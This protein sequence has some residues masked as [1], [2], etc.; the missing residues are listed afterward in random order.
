MIVFMV[1]KLVM[2]HNNE[3]SWRI[4]ENAFLNICFIIYEFK[5]IIIYFVDK[6]KERK[7]VKSKRL[8]GML[9]VFLLVSGSLFAQ[10]RVYR[11]GDVGPAGGI[12][13][14]DKGFSQDGWR[15]LEVAPAGAE[16]TAEWGGRRL[17]VPGTSA[18][19]GSGKRNTQL[20]VDML[21]SKGEKE[22]AAQLCAG[23]DINGFK[24]WFLPSIDELNHL[25]LNRDRIGGFQNARYWSST[26][27]NRNAAK[28]VVFSVE[29]NG[30]VIILPG[31][32][33]DNNKFD[34]RRVRPVRSF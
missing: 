25:Y 12:I 24:D 4:V 13:Y 1:H 34:N 27:H 20:I 3:T 31:T 22:R 15:Y 19:M 23:L 14:F 18:A 33:S 11:V 32:I 5:R 28:T 21:N 8:L 16:F 10:E 29:Y 26:Q 2:R 7:M 6:V 9:V 17:D 30:F